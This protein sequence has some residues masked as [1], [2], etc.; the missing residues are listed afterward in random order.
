MTMHYDKFDSLLMQGKALYAKKNF[1]QAIKVYSE[2]ITLCESDD[3]ELS[4]CLRNRALCHMKLS[5]FKESIEDSTDAYALQPSNPKP[6]YVLAKSYEMSGDFRNAL[7]NF[8][9]MLVVDPC[10]AEGKLGV[11]RLQAMVTADREEVENATDTPEVPK[12]RRRTS[13]KFNTSSFTVPSPSS[14][15]SSST[16]SS[17]HIMPNAASTGHNHDSSTPHANRS[18]AVSVSD[19]IPMSSDGLPPMHPAVV[20]AME[21]ANE[22]LQELSLRSTEPLEDVCTSTCEGNSDDSPIFNPPAPPA[23]TQDSSTDTLAEES[24]V[25]NSTTAAAPPPHKQRKDIIS[26]LRQHQATAG[27]GQEISRRVYAVSSKWWTAWVGFVTTPS[28]PPPAQSVPVVRRFSARLRQSSSGVGSSDMSKTASPGRILN[29]AICQST[30][31]NGTDGE[32]TK[33]V[34]MLRDDI[35]G[36]DA[37]SVLVCNSGG[38]GDVTGASTNVSV[39]DATSEEQEEPGHYDK[40]SLLPYPLSSPTAKASASAS[41]ED[42]DKAEVYGFVTVPEEVW[43]ALQ[44]WYGNDVCIPLYRHHAAATSDSENGSVLLSTWFKPWCAGPDTNTATSSSKSSGSSATTVAA[45]RYYHFCA[46][47]LDE[48]ALRCSRCKEV[49]YCSVTCQSCDWKYHQKRCKT[50]GHTE[51]EVSSQGTSPS[52]SNSYYSMLGMRSK[53]SVHATLMKATSRVTCRGMMGL[54]NLGNSCYFNASLQCMSHT[55]PLTKYFISRQYEPHVNTT[56]RDGTGGVLAKEY[57]LLLQQMWLKS[58]PAD[59]HRPIDMRRLI[60]RVN[61]DYATLQQQD[62]HDVLVFLLDRLHEDVNKVKKKPY[63]ENSEGNGEDDDVIS[64]ESWDKHR[65][66][67]DSVVQEIIGGQLRSQ[68]GLDGMVLKCCQEC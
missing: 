68:V 39:S 22:P 47:C 45:Q 65:L 7:E 19:E 17:T 43:D 60:G 32:D 49:Y 61:E 16:S 57:G 44:S 55:F 50:S 25:V 3:I 33:E 15:S 12:S 1:K 10:S 8:K 14:L 58:F 56:S 26:L 54:A 23:R 42:D 5:L 18:R 34:V 30:K 35:N 21:L 28:E 36:F 24:P 29:H 46:V 20:F 13:L 51:N 38:D 48:G 41:G 9:K 66:R 40:D 4:A 2:A 63:V 53:E 52:K 37:L 59:E 64:R 31:V 67:H 62:A 6:L 27:R 11:G